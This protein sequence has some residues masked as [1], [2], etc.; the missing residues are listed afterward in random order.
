MPPVVYNPAVVVVA[1][2]AAS[3]AVVNKTYTEDGDDFSTCFLIIFDSQTIKNVPAL[4]HRALFS[5][6]V[7]TA[8]PAAA[9]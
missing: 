6:V 8:A 1:A 4:R 9:R 3:M 5:F 7:A 2:A